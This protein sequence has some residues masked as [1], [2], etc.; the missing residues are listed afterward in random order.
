[1]LSPAIRIHWLEDGDHGFKPRKGSGRTERE[2]WDTAMGAVV[3][4]I[5]GLA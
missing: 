4:F 5:A 3:G 2:N 1:M